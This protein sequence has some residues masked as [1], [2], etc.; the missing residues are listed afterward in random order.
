MTVD[1]PVENSILLPEWSRRVTCYYWQ[2]D[3]TLPT[4][5]RTTAVNVCGS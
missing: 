2:H 1:W 5:C 4:Y 3:R